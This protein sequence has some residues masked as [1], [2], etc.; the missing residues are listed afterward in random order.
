[1]SAAEPTE[2]DE[3]IERAI[4]PHTHR[5]KSEVR[6]EPIDFPLARRATNEMKVRLQMVFRGFSEES[7]S[8][9]NF[10]SA[11]S[12]VQHYEDSVARLPDNHPLVDKSHTP[13]DYLQI[14][15]EKNGEAVKQELLEKYEEGSIPHSFVSIMGAYETAFNLTPQVSSRLTLKYIDSARAELAPKIV[16]LRQKYSI[17]EEKAAQ[18]AVAELADTV[19]THITRVKQVMEESNLPPQNAQAQV[20]LESVRGKNSSVEYPAIRLSAS[21]KQG[22]IDAYH[23]QDRPY[24]QEE[25]E[26]AQRLMVENKYV[27]PMLIGFHEL[28]VQYSQDY[29]KQHPERMA[30][31]LEPYNPIFIPIRTDD[32]TVE[33]FAPNPKL[34]KTMSQHWIPAIAREM[35]KEAAGREVNPQSI[36]PDQIGKAVGAAE[37][38]NIFSTVLGEFIQVPESDTVEWKGTFAQVCPAKNMFTNA[39]REVLPIVYNYF[40]TL[41]QAQAA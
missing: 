20:V 41:D 9:L 4:G 24:T 7:L 10:D 23:I 13:D 5:K 15:V 27:K 16:L 32:G 14:R 8:A 26:F 21:D 33:S 29:M 1:M 40:K 39:G 37:D 34:L 36:E 28:F 17:S 35:L 31:N 2:I 30:Q 18:I 11:D 22:L 25:L 6:G 3:Y 12:A 19:D 38:Y